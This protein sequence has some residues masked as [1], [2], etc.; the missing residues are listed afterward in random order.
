MK[1]LIISKGKYRLMNIDEVLEEFRPAAYT[2]FKK[3]SKCSNMTEDDIQELDITIFKAFQ[4]YDEKHCF[5]T[6]LSWQIRRYITVKTRTFLKSMNGQG[7][8]IKNLDHIIGEDTALHELIGDDK[9]DIEFDII[10][11][12]F[13]RYIKEK[14]NIVEQGLVDVYLGKMTMSALAK[15]INR[16]PQTVCKANSKF[17]KRLTGLMKRYDRNLFNM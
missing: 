6:H 9:I 13:I 8:E 15:Q 16:T 11:N 10:Q 7:F 17:K 12:D 14:S 3:Y 5:T 2:L 1:K 4:T